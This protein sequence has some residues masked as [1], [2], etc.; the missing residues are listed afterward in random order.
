[1]K[2]EVTCSNCGGAN[3]AY[4]LNCNKCG[5]YLRDR[6]VNIDLWKTF[7]LIIV[8]PAEGFTLIRNS[9]HKNFL[10]FL[11][12]MLSVKMFFNSALISFVYYSTP[13]VTARMALGFAVSAGIFLISTLLFALSLK[14]IAKMLKTE[15][16]FWDNV[17]VYIYSFFP[18]LVGLIL[19]LPLEYIIYGEY[20]FSTNPSW[21]ALNNSFAYLFAGL[22]AAAFLWQLFL[23]YCAIKVQTNSRLFSLLFGLVFIFITYLA[24]FVISK[25]LFM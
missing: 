8:S 16:R 7:G 19:L 13:N 4:K 14:Y 1:M 18:Y 20:L 3:P 6:V 21:F 12:L 22:E 9:E 15:T 23:L 5:S 17:S 25:Y 24:Y 10:L 11:F 2:N